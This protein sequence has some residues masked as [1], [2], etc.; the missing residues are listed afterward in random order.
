[1]GWTTSQLVQEHKASLLDAREFFTAPNDADFLRHLRVAGRVVSREKRPLTRSAQL[2]LQAGVATYDAP[3]D[4]VL[5][6]S[7]YWGVALTQEKPWCAP[8]T[9]LP[10]LRLVESDTASVLQLTPA[11]TVEQ[12]A[13]LGVAYPFWYIAAYVVPDTG[14]SDVTDAEVDLILLRAK[15]EAMRELAI[16][17]SSAPVTLRTSQGAGGS[18]TARNQ[19]PRALYQAF[20]DEFKAA[21]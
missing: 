12:I 20:L 2:I 9:P 18:G 6:K 17:S 7:S 13:A 3:A 15:V 19:T 1:M 5:P 21:A 14:D 16:R 11:P 4:L 8:R 10:A